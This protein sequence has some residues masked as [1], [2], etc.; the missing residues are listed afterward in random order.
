[1]HSFSWGG[2]PLRKSSF[3]RNPAD[4]W[5]LYVSNISLRPPCGHHRS[6]PPVE[7]Q[8]LWRHQTSA[9][10]MN[11]IPGRIPSHSTCLGSRLVKN[12][13]FMSLGG[14]IFM[15]QQK[16]PTAWEPTKSSKVLCRLSVKVGAFQSLAGVAMPAE[17]IETASEPKCARHQT[18][19]STW[20]YVDPWKPRW[21]DRRDTNDILFWSPKRICNRKLCKQVI[22]LPWILI[23]LSLEIPHW[24]PFAVLN[25]HLSSPPC[26]VQGIRHTLE[27]EWT[28]RPQQ[29][30]N[31]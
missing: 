21:Q 12:H 18:C 5:Y 20:Q 11:P 24:E 7:V 30:N 8:Q 27:E 14:L 23:I 9:T 31:T 22:D 6:L 2:K 1:M 29:G 26:L 17:D 25:H 10:Q 4:F 15:S 19:N 16:H 3:T 28:G 13:I